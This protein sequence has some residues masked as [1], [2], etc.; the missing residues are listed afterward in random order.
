MNLKS[1][2]QGEMQQSVCASVLNLLIFFGLSCETM[3]KDKTKTNNSFFFKELDAYTA[4][5]DS[6]PG[7]KK[8]PVVLSFN[9]QIL[10][11]PQNQTLSLQKITRHIL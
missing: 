1:L 4:S 7:N 3:E 10:D 8:A 5:K 2:V 6:D 9:S 11:Q